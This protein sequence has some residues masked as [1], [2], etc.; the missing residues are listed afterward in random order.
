MGPPC[1][2]VELVEVEAAL[3][4]VEAGGVPVPVVMGARISKKIR[5]GTNFLNTY[6]VA[7]REVEFRMRELRRVEAVD[8]SHWVEVQAGVDLQ[9]GLLGLLVVA[10]VLEAVKFRIQ[11][12][13]PKKIFQKNSYR[14]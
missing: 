12:L 4:A 9:E 10:H 5:I 8:C 11:K 7:A 6:A 14:Q 13:F 3:E 2:L 1:A